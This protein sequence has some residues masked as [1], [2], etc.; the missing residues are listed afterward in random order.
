MQIVIVGAGVVGTALAE[1]L[2][3]EGHQV[4]VIDRD[5]HKVRELSEKLDVLGVHGNAAMP[6]VLRR[7]GIQEAQMVIAVTDVDEVNVIVGMMAMRLGV[8]H[9]IV[10]IRNSEYLDENCIISP[11][12]LGIE[13]VINPEPAI[14]DALVRMIEIPGSVDVATLAGGQVLMLGFDIEEDSPA[15]G[16]TTA[17]LREVSDLDSFL[18]IDIMRGDEVIVPKGNDRILPGDNVHILV[19]EGT[20][21]FLLPIIHRQRRQTARVILLGASRIGVEL[22]KAMEGRVERMVLIEPDPG[23]AEEAASVLKK[24]TVLQGEGTDLEVLEEAS[25]GTCDLFC[26]VSDNDQRNMLAALLARKHGAKK[27]AV[28]VHQPEFVPVLDSLGVEIVINPRLVT[29]SEALMHVRRGLVH[30]VTRLAGSRGEIL[31]IEAQPGSRVVGAPLKA[32]NFPK[33]ALVGAIVRDDIMQIPTGD[34]IIQPGERVVVYA[35]QE[36]IAAIEKL[37]A[38]TSRDGLPMR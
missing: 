14:V 6:S 24:T 10:R 25:I 2:S 28:L 5:R 1:Q 11:Q 33:N 21:P 20:V 30:S 35:L 22:A 18:F 8:E 26:A 29:V 12:E 16:K 13:H 32:L 4:S 27:E 38:G 9:R 7:A 23:L 36:A 3:H 15:A 37:F 19:A 31:E 34:T 17:E